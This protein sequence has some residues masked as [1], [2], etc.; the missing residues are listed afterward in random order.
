ME[1]TVIALSCSGLGKK[2]HRSGE[3]VTDADF[4]NGRANELVASGFLKVVKKATKNEDEQT[5]DDG[6]NVVGKKG[7][8]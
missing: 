4:P 6:K 1:Y 2:I 7:K 5:G 8:K 3:I